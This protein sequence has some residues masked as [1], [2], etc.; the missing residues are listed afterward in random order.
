MT[1]GDCLC[2]KPKMKGPFFW[3]HNSLAWFSRGE[4]NAYYQKGGHKDGKDYN[5]RNCS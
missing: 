5:K 4:A 3:T 1:A 2:F